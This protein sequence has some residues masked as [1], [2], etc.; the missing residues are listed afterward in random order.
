MRFESKPKDL[1]H[2][3]KNFKNIS[4][5]M[6]E[7]HQEALCFHLRS[8][9]VAQLGK[10][11]SVGPG[12]FAP[13]N[14]VIVW[15]VVATQTLDHLHVHTDMHVTQPLTVSYTPT[16]PL[17][18]TRPPPYTPE[19]TISTVNELLYKEILLEEGKAEDDEVTRFVCNL[20]FLTC[21]LMYV[22]IGLPGL[23]SMAHTWECCCA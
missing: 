18:H 1:A 21:S 9:L 16:H 13:C 22:F 7:W 14:C 8:S 20:L 4:K 10:N 6:A 15:D 5:T 23:K 17:T 12:M 19:V 11:T 2:R 3:V